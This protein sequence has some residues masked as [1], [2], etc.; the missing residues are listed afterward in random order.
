MW[1]IGLS[2]AL[3]VGLLLTSRV[4]VPAAP[5]GTAAEHL[6]QLAAQLGSEKYQEREEATQAL[7]D[8][9]APALEVLRVA[10][11]SDDL[12]IRRRAEELVT[13][14]ER[15]L[16]TAQLLEPKR[17]RLAYKDTPVAE[18][19]RDLARR[20]GY[21]V[22]VQGDLGKLAQRRITLETEDLP[23]WEAFDRF[24]RR[25]GLVERGLVP[26]PRTPVQASADQALALQ[27][28]QKGYVPDSRVENRFVLVDGQPPALPG[29]RDGAVQIQALPP[30]PS[31]WGHARRP[32]EALLVLDVAP[33]PKLAW[34]ST[35]EVRIDRAVD[36]HGQ[37]LAQA[38]ASS[39]PKNAGIMMGNGVVLWNTV[40]EQPL[41]SP[42]HV[43]VRLA[44][45]DKPSK[46]LKE[47]RGTLSA[48]VQTPLQPLITV[49]QVLLAVGQTF[50]GP[51]GESLKVVEAGRQPDGLM[52]L[53]IQV[54]GPIQGQ[55]I[56]GRGGFRVNRVVVM[57]GG[58]RI[59]VNREW[60][61]G[62]S[63][64]SL[65]DATGKSVPLV[66]A[67]SN[68]VPSGTSVAQEHQLS[69]QPAAVQS[70][71]AALVYRGR[72]TVVLDIPFTLKDVPLP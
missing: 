27:L 28:L 43:A 53:R 41:S 33:E 71:P 40:T 13:Q 62:S 70:E 58:G 31:M 21:P 47:L 44:R 69:Y 15:R 10:A 12:E 25:A 63:T 23:F 30:S 67:E 68:L 37:Q 50:K 35:L 51:D 54:E 20:S 42:R 24:C 59:G 64:L 17:L 3:L 46:V 36:E 29:C 61:G 66:R 26:L 11:R 16:L 6:A 56:L 45:G 55:V 60:D 48:Q 8:I 65:L 52:R 1:N 2:S 14:I 34:H 22:Q 4:V 57:N 32:G 49:D 7:D 19:V 72:R 9:G 18:A 39:D 38:G 5:V